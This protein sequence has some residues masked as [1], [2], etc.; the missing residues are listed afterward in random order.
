MNKRIATFWVCVGWFAR[1]FPDWV[2]I[3]L[4]VIT[5]LAL[6]IECVLVVLEKEEK[7]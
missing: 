7:E 5:A 3:A 4:G 6:A 1:D 2:F